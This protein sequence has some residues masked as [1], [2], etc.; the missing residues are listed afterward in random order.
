MRNTTGE[1]IESTCGYG[2]FRARPR[3]VSKKYSTLSLRKMD[4]KI[5][6]GNY[7]W[8]VRGGNNE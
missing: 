5:R 8:R 3:E 6:D 2:T 7:A 4:S 1:K